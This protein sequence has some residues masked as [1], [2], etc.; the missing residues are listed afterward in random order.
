MAEQADLESRYGT[1]V[2]ISLG[3]K[4]VLSFSS[5]DVETNLFSVNG[6]NVTNDDVG[7][8]RIDVEAKFVDP[9]GRIQYFTRPFYLHIREDPS[10]VPPEAPFEEKPEP[11]EGILTSETF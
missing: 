10:Q 3:M 11:D 9:Q 6:Q 4:R 7:A 5:F 1:D 2:E 8:W